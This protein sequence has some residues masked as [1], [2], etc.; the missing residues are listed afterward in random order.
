MTKYSGYL[1]YVLRHRW[2]VMVEC[3]RRG[4][5]WQGLMHDLDKFLPDEFFPYADFFNSKRRDKT[6]YYKPTD[7]GHAGFD[8]AW[9]RHVHRNRHHW[10]HW[11]QAT[12][13]GLR[14]FDIPRKHVIEMVCDWIGAGRAQYSETNAAQWFAANN[15]KMQLTPTTKAMIEEY[16]RELFGETS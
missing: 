12:E 10:Q 4:L 14:L 13:D 16:L 9:L 3:F 11:T 1:L 7:T 5:Y 6:G 8:M 2:F 15:H